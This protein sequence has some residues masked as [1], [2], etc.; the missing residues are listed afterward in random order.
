VAFDYSFMAFMAFV[1]IRL[2]MKDALSYQKLANKTVRCRVCQRRCVI[3]EGKTGFCLT[4]LNREGKLY[5]LNYGLIQGVQVDPIEK[6][7]FYH[8]LPGSLVPSV[9]SYGCNFRCK[10]CLNYWC[11]WGDQATSALKE[12]QEK[13]L[14][15]ISP[16]QLISQIRQS[17]YH[18]IAFTYNEPVVWAEYVLDAAKLAKKEGFFTLFVTN[19]SWTK[20]TLDKI[21]PYIDAANIDFKGFSTKTY[22]RMGGYFGQIS[23]MAKYAKSKHKIFIEIT[24]LLIPGINDDPKELREMT[25]W[26]AKNLGPKTPW[27]L[28]QFDPDISPDP[29]FQKIPFTTVDELEKAA[30][31][32]QKAG[33]EFIYIWAPSSAY[34]KGDTFCP[35]C[36][37]LCVKRSGWQPEILAVDKEGKCT[38]CGEDL[39][40]RI[41]PNEN[42]PNKSEYSE[43]FG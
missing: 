34:S 2:F 43:K 20:E 24:T 8:F 13:N 18:G 31:I 26:I 3:A 4:K 6:K 42:N 27:H 23:E 36:K 35:K 5:T 11:S 16:D 37:T 28:S 39:H 38:K 33:L 1:F 41:N 15:S 10:Q 7:P 22:T 32:G 21:G 12:A 9:G 25:N 14:P 19:G 17:G 30:E 29:K 40:I